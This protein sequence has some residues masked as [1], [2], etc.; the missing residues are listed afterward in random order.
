L[1][2]LKEARKL[3][4]LRRK[5]ILDVLKIHPSYLSNMENNQ[6]TVPEFRKSQFINLYRAYGVKETI[7]F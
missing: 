6:I 4:G 1:V 2:T 3:S 5:Y 7:K